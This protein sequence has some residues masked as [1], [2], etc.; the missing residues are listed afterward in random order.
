[1]SRYFHPAKVTFALCALVLC[2]SSWR[3][4]AD[5]PARVWKF[6]DYTMT[7]ERTAGSDMFDQDLLTIRKA[8]NLVHAEVAAHINFVTPAIGEAELPEAV[9]ISMAAGKDIVIQSFSGGAHCCFSIVVATLAERFHA[10]FPL[11]LRDAGAALFKLPE[12]EL[13]GLRSADEAYAYRWTSFVSS[14]SPEILLRYDLEKGFTAAIDLMHKPSLAPDLLR[15]MAQKMGKDVKAWKEAGD[16]PT[17]EYLKTVMDLIYAGDQAG[18]R[19][20]AAAAW[21]DWKPGRSD[22]VNDLYSCAL[23]ASPWWNDVGALNGIKPYE[24]GKDC[25]AN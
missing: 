19:E 7:V 8:G 9:P 10:S 22:F 1:M 3:V 16:S 24:K 14:P 6:G 5:A 11:D 21:P 20:Y 12:S 17:A 15:Q 23:P 18:A 25:P 13:Y 2:L 4:R